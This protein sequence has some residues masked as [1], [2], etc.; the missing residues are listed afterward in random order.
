M[1]S[2]GIRI[3][4][5]RP[6]DADRSKMTIISPDQHLLEE[7]SKPSGKSLQ[8]ETKTKLCQT[9]TALGKGNGGVSS[10]TTDAI[11]FEVPDVLE[12]SMDIS[13]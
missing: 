10:M 3:R 1:P 5:I 2:L 8:K 7:S 4:V 9:T 6:A 13:Q 12:A 11:T